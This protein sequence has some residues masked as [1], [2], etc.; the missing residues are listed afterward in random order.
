MISKSSHVWHLSFETLNSLKHSEVDYVLRLI[1]RDNEN[2]KSLFDELKNSQS[3]RLPEVFTKPR[4]ITY[5]SGTKIEDISQLV[6]PKQLTHQNK[7]LIHH[8]L[9]KLQKKKGYRTAEEV[10]AITILRS[11]LATGVVPETAKA[12]HKDDRD[13]D[14]DSSRGSEHS[15]GDRSDKG[16]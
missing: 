15:K 10:E 5:Q 2:A 9:E 12:I 8:I 1:E 3:A 11:F 6:I 14:G 13:R 7:K 16:G 4:T